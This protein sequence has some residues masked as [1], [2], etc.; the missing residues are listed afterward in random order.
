MTNTFLW[1]QSLTKPFWAPPGWLFG[2]VWTI[3]YIIIAI[4]FGAV[5]YKTLKKEFSWKIALPFL[6]NLFFNIIFTPIQF[7]LQNNFGAAI[8]IVL[9][10]ATLVWALVVIYKKVNWVFWVNIPY[11]AWVSFAT[12]LQMTIT[13]LNW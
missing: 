4:S 3:L 7:N 10:L 8:D 13:Y 12:V 6:L 11:L 1:Y 2:P 9:V 5:F